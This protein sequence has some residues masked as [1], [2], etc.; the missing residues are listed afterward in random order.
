MKTRHKIALARTAYWGLIA[1]RRSVGKGHSACV[2]RS[3]LNWSLD[4]REGIDLAIYLQGKF[5]P[6]TVAAYRRLIEPGQTVLDIGANIGAHT[7]HLAEAVG[8]RGRVLA[9]EPTR[10]AFCKLK[11]NVEANPALA[12]QIAAEQI[13]LGVS[14][15]GPLGPETYSSWPLTS[16]GN[17]HPLHRGALETTDGAAVRSLDSYVLQAGIPQVHLIKI[18]VDGAE[19]EVLS[20][21]QDVLRAHRPTIVMEFAPYLL[22][23]RGASVSQLF[24]LLTGYEYV[25]ERGFSS[26]SID[27]LKRL[28]S[29]GSS[30]N[31]IAVA[32]TPGGSASD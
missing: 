19:C 12:N 23:E 25:R 29:E 18:D 24:E 21:A 9:F 8:S 30:I 6:T 2:R 14:D 26:I 20:G 17:R 3:G 28:A 27:Q 16:R 32:R 11:C 1:A 5:E 7:L 10:Y 22:A 31:V 13:M 15:D 4:L